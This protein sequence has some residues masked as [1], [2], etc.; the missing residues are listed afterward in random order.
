ML[1]LVRATITIAR[2]PIIVRSL[3]VRGWM[4]GVAKAS[5]KGSYD[6][7]FCK[8]TLPVKQDYP[9][10]PEQVTCCGIVVPVMNSLNE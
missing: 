10:W 3:R 8:L 9:V 4:K 6:N 7:F 1:L 5:T 2:V